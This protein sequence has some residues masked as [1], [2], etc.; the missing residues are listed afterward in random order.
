MPEPLDY[1]TP[2]TPDTAPQIDP[3]APSARPAIPVEFDTLL[4]QTD[5]HAA[6]KAIEVALHR[7]NIPVFSAG[8]GNIVARQIDLYIRAADH[9]R[10]SKI[11]AQIFARRKKLKSLPRQKMLRE[12]QPDSGLF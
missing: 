7:E 2:G 3:P 5:D 12:D 11:A 6:A 4:A 10:A 9:E 8:D 1:Q